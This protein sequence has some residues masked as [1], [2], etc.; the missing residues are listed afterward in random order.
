MKNGADSLIV[1]VIATYIMGCNG[2][3]VMWT[4]HIQDILE[5]FGEVKRATLT[6]GMPKSHLYFQ[7]EMFPLPTHN[8]L[9][10]V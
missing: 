6:F 10:F 8:I 5:P 7:S 4:G 9:S 1:F 2:R 3:I